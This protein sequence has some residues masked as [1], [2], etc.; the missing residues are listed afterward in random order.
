MQIANPDSRIFY[1]DLIKHEIIATLKCGVI[2]P[3]LYVVR[4]TLW[5]DNFKLR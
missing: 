1:W 3:I 2:E 5:D 4:K